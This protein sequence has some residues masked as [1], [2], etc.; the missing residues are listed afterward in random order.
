M[1]DAIFSTNKGRLPPRELRM[2]PPRIILRSSPDEDMESMVTEL[3]AKFPMECKEIV[4]PPA[5]LGDYFD[6]YDQ[7][8]HGALF[9]SSVLKAISFRNQSRRASV[10]N[11]AHEWLQLNPMAF[12]QMLA[13]EL[14]AFTEDDIEEFGAEFMQEVL[15]VL[16]GWKLDQNEGGQYSLAFSTA[17]CTCP[18]STDI[19]PRSRTCCSATAISAGQRRVNAL[20]HSTTTTAFSRRRAQFLGSSIPQQCY[21]SASDASSLANLHTKRILRASRSRAVSAAAPASE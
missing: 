4:A 14:D 2:I 1:G 7:E 15:D 3:Q 19:N 9:L 5:N 8:L 6:A 17:T 11:V 21:E 20:P 18:T 13:Y 10:C 16:Q 12:G